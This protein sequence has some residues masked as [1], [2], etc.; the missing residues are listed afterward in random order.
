MN[1]AAQQLRITIGLLE[2]GKKLGGR[3]VKL[4]EN[5]MHVPKTSMTNI[6]CPIFR[7]RLVLINTRKWIITEECTLIG[8]FDDIYPINVPNH[9]FHIDKFQ[10]SR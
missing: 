5:G 7:L 10:Y 8:C 2:T 4:I 6:Y 1:Q 3:G 9:L